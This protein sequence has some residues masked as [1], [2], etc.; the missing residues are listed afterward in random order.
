MK[1][2]FVMFGLAMALVWGPL[3]FAGDIQ[4]MSDVEWESMKQNFSY[5]PGAQVAI[6][7]EGVELSTPESSWHPRC[8]VCPVYPRCPSGYFQVGY[9]EV[10]NKVCVQ[11]W[12]TDQ[13]GPGGV[14]AIRS[15]TIVE[16][17]VAVHDH[18]KGA[19]CK[20]N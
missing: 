10:V 5:P 2:L 1:R 17:G 20:K 15:D 19:H 7:A 6:P 8:R 3:A 12:G 9:T 11:A 13:V 4:M 18:I 14:H 16:N